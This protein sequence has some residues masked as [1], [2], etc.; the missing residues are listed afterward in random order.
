MNIGAVFS[1]S[2]YGAPRGPALCCDSERRRGERRARAA[3]KSTGTAREVDAPT[4]VRRARARDHAGRTARELVELARAPTLESYKN[5]PRDLDLDVQ[6]PPGGGLS[7]RAGRR[8][9]F[10]DS[11]GR[12]PP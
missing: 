4:A 10:R 3:R 2:R 8:I 6:G 9:W 5:E 1:L 7:A 12:A 11:P